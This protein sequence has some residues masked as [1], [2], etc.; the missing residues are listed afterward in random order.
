MLGTLKQGRQTYNPLWGYAL[1]LCLGLAAT[2]WLGLITFKWLGLSLLTLVY[3]LWILWAAYFLP[4]LTAMFTVFLAVILINYFFID[5]RFT[6]RIGS[7]QSWGMLSVFSVVAITV[8]H[9]MHKLKQQAM[10]AQLAA[11]QAAFFQSLA[12]TLSSHSSVN[13]SLQAAC[14]LL[15][16]TFDWQIR[17]VS[18]DAALNILHIAGDDRL[19]VSAASVQWAIDYQRAIG[20]GTPD[21]SMLTMCIVPFKQ[22]LHE[23]LVVARPQSL[24]QSSYFSDI[25]FLQTV[26]E[27]CTVT[28]LKLRQQHALAEATEQMREDAFKKTLLTALS[29]DMRTPL[30]AIL[31]ATNVLSDPHIPLAA[32]QRLQ[33]LQSIQSEADYLNHA[34]ENILTLV[35]LEAGERTLRC[36]WQSLHEVIQHVAQRYQ[37][38]RPAETIV[39]DTLTVNPAVLVNIDAILVAHA[40][41]NL[42]DNALQWRALQTPI[43]LQLTQN[44]HRLAVTVMNIGAGFSK[45]FDIAAFQSHPT[46]KHSGRGFGLGLHIVQ[47]IMHLHHGH[48][49]HGQQLVE[50]GTA[51]T[52]SDEECPNNP[53]PLYDTW[54]TMSFP[55]NSAQ[56]SLAVPE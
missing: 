36:E 26:V 50:T 34:T 31:G 44:D 8:S 1:T 41:S 45:G 25:H 56:A 14:D 17:I 12:Q 7:V 28:T 48:L 42:V 53:T 32:E 33:L 3:M 52:I 27:Q 16:Q 10:Q 15:H 37:Q 6:L 29:H 9:L 19:E 18:V 39:V 22:P 21:W 4:G 11:K 35:K 5:P 47:T 51:S 49:H 24:T 46:P 20:A 2:T 23:V 13:Q 55:V 38:R 54:V 40:L 43:T 30:T